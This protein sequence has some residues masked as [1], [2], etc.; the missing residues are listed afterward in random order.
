MPG[1]FAGAVRRTVAETK[2]LLA[3]TKQIIVR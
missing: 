2:Q 3:L 1:P